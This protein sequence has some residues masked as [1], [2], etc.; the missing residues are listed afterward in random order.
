MVDR[1]KKSLE[2]LDPPYCASCALE[3]NWSRSSLVDEVTIVHIFVCP[4][5]SSTAE[6]KSTIRATGVP[7]KKLSAPRDRQ[8]A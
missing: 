7:P 6:R 8:A 4:G 1:L 3:M 5:C 2:H